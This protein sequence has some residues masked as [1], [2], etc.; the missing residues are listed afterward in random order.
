MCK[1]IITTTNGNQI[2]VKGEIQKKMDDAI[3]AAGAV[4]NK[5]KELAQKLAVVLDLYNSIEW[6]DLLREGDKKPTF[7][8]LVGQKCPGVKPS[9]AYKYA[10]TY[11][12]IGRKYPTIYDALSL[13]KS[14]ALVPLDNDKKHSVLEFFGEFGV[15]LYDEAIA[16]NAPIEHEREELETQLKSAA[17]DTVRRALQSAIANLH[18]LYDLPDNDGA[19]GNPTA[20]S[21]QRYGIK[22][23]AALTDDEFRKSVALY[24]NDWAIPEPKTPTLDSTRGK[25]ATALE[26]LLAQWADAPEVVRDALKAIKPTS[27]SGEETPRG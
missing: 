22:H 25:A 14:I 13:G 21:L 6:K 1:L 16:H 24:R 4:A 19:D 26:N 8:D 2:E 27:K 10:Q 3:K 23:S 9:M 15:R 17:N 5:S 20:E 12:A 7:P 11:V 18:P